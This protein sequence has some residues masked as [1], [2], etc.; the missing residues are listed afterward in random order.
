MPE[1]GRVSNFQLAL[2]WDE[3]RWLETME[4]LLLMAPGSAIVFLLLDN[5]ESF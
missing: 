4:L 3:E 5:G 1:D 2:R